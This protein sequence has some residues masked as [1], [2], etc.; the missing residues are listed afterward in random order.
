[1]RRYILTGT[2]GAG[3]TPILLELERRGHPVVREAATDVIPR[4]A[5]GV[6]RHWER[7]SLID[8]I[9]AVQR[10]R[11]AAPATAGSG[12]QFCGSA[13]VLPSAHW[14]W[15]NI[16]VI[17]RLRPWSQR[18]TASAANASTNARCS[19]SRDLGFV[20]R[21]DARRIAYEQS[22]EFE[23]VH[24]A[25]YTSLG[26]QLIDVPRGTVADRADLIEGAI[27]SWT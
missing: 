1:M 21:T 6:D 17:L 2:P 16:S 27:Q 4:A 5:R 18:S 23:A 11:Q 13:T 15:P 9:L 22:L 25:T 3:K 26:Y 10:E 20:E 19:S 14:L 8:N 7:A 12:A 24:I